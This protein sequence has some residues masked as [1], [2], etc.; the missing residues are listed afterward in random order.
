MGL[1]VATPPRRTRPRGRGSHRHPAL[2]TSPRSLPSG[3]ICA[4]RRFLPRCPPALRLPTAECG[5]RCCV[6]GFPTRSPPGR[7]R[8]TLC[9]WLGR[10]GL[11]HIGLG[12]RA[13]MMRRSLPARVHRVC[14]N[15]SIPFALHNSARICRAGHH[16]ARAGRAGPAVSWSWRRSERPVGRAGTLS[17][18]RWAQSLARLVP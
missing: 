1:T 2:R 16:F 5:R 4:R 9:F 12:R 11:G 13:V 3:G 17:F 7:G 6:P 15:Y 14:C 18:A 10:F 8:G